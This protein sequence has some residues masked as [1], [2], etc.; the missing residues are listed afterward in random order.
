MP[1][2]AGDAVVEVRGLTLESDTAAQRAARL[3]CHNRIW[4]DLAPN[5]RGAMR[6][7]ADLGHGSRRG[8]HFPAKGE[9]AIYPAGM[10]HFY[11]EWDRRMARRAGP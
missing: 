1:V 4:G 8:D 7:I 2:K 6:E 11:M 3:R 5:A 10:E 9:S